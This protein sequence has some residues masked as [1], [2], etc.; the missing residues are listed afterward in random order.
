MGQQQVADVLKKNSQRWMTSQEI[1]LRL[2]I[3]EISVIRCLRSLKKRDEIQIK[4]IPGGR[5]RLRTLYRIK[6]EE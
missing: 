3:N 1:V 5:G 2:T 6:V 4:L